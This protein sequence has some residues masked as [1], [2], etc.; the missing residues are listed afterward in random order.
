[1][2]NIQEQS[3][4]ESDVEPVTLFLY[5]LLKLVT[6]PTHSFTKNRAWVVLLLQNITHSLL[7]LFPGV[8]SQVSLSRTYI[9]DSPA[10]IPL[11][12][13]KISVEKWW[14]HLTSL[15]SS[16]QGELTWF[17][18]TMAGAES[19]VGTREVEM[20]NGLGC[21][22]KFFLPAVCTT[23]NTVLVGFVICASEDVPG[24]SGGFW[25]GQSD[26][27]NRHCQWPAWGGCD[28]AR[29][30]IAVLRGT[31]MRVASPPSA[32]IWLHSVSCRVSVW[33][34]WYAVWEEKV[35]GWS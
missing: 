6:L 17:Q 30:A 3:F 7:R 23:L 2:L 32:G 22:G 14:I 13:I 24:Q 15:P 25:A 28:P 9:T 18:V 4:N 29:T 16:L 5:T 1:M 33:S 11:N 10:F 8:S 19:R 31:A 26:L 27:Q 35:G 12:F 34:A 21:W 20:R